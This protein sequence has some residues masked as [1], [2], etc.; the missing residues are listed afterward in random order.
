MR[1]GI[2]LSLEASHSFPV[3]R[4]TWR[5]VCSVTTRSSTTPGMGAGSR[6]ATW[7]A[8]PPERLAGGAGAARVGRMFFP[9]LGEGFTANMEAPQKALME[10]S[11][12]KG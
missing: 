2:F 9:R 11:L 5:Q 3:I 10:P 4:V 6:P 12:P 8:R 7:P 1:T